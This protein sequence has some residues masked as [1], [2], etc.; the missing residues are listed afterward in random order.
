MLSSSLILADVERLTDSL[1]LSY[2]L[3]LSDK[4]SEFE[5][6]VLVDSL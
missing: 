2:V 1:W 4:L 6:L 5:R 3:W